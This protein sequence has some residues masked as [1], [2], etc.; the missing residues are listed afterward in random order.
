M[1]KSRNTREMKSLS[2][3]SD[4]HV[5]FQTSQRDFLCLFDVVTKFSF[6]RWDLCNLN[7][8]QAPFKRSSLALLWVAVHTH[9]DDFFQN[10]SQP[11]L[12]GVGFFLQQA[13][14]AL[15][16]FQT[17]AHRRLSPAQRATKPS[18]PANHGQ[19]S[20]SVTYPREGKTLMR[21]LPDIS[22]L[23]TEA[24]MT[25][26]R[27]TGPGGGHLTDTSVWSWDFRLIMEDKH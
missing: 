2:R 24:A 7:H 17:G 27:F 13:V 6:V 15:G 10:Q 16:A 1:L 5:Y 23:T 8:I 21:S 12:E 18:F 3:I 22:K 20:C 9:I 26:V 14:A 11:Q 4:L 19:F 25:T